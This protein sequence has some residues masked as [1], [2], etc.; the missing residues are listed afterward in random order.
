MSWCRQYKNIN[1]TS[2]LDHLTSEGWLW[3]AKRLSGN[4]TGLTGGH[5][6][7][8]YLPRWFFE[9]VFPEIC[10]TTTYN[11]R[12]RIGACYFPDNDL[13]VEGVNAIYYNSKFFP[14]RRLKKKYNEF[15]ITG[16]GG[17][18]SSPLQNAENTGCITIVASRR[19]GEETAV[20]LWTCADAEQEAQVES[21]LGRE[22]LPGEVVGRGRTESSSV[23]ESLKS[24]A[25][26]YLLPK[27]LRHFPTGEEIFSQVSL[28][29]PYDSWKRGA[30]A[31][32]L[33]RRALEFAMFE[34][35]EEEHL[36]PQIAR[37]FR[38]VDPFLSLALS[39]ANRRK[40]RTGRS[41]ELN[42]AS[43]FAGSQ[44]RFE[45]QAVTESNK[46]PDF[47][48][49]SAADYHNLEFPN[50]RLHMI[51]A[52]TCCKDRWRQIINEADRISPKHLFT[53]QE[54]V[55]ENQLDEMKRSH[56]VLVVPKP[57]KK[58]FPE[59]KR[60]EV[61]DLEGFVSF[62]RQSQSA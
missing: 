31:L 51:G 36:L 61:M 15:R 21:W 14:E 28:A 26:R 38:S 5:Q 40:S 47:L 13:L 29:L 41:L 48:F 45:E 6:A 3:A 22:L 56:V 20:I 42:L 60:D 58:S 19:F 7:G 43:I 44:L 1:L 8:I 27:W 55:S 9:S 4:D 49:P 35:V 62:I 24:L 39:V 30:D 25:R 34:V 10:T 32:L 23:T 52:K 57:N 53:L 54:G 11:P 18:Q 16:W 59:S 33:R 50:E 17:R 46:R 12:T 37:G 2:F